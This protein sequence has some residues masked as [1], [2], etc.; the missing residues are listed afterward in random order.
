MQRL[1]VTGAVRPLYG[2]LGVKGLIYVLF[3]EDGRSRFLRNID[4]TY[5]NTRDHI[6]VICFSISTFSTEPGIV[7][8]YDIAA[9]NIAARDAV[10]LIFVG[11]V[12]LCKVTLHNVINR[13]DIQPDTHVH[14][15]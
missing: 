9:L 3:C 1:E 8:L 11:L 7:Q 4:T 13:F 14:T 15:L 6:P 5:P 10:K 2:S 12:T